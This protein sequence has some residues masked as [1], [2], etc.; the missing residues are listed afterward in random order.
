MRTDARFDMRNT[1][2]NS[3]AASQSPETSM[4]EV[5]S[6]ANVNYEKISYFDS[7]ALLRYNMCMAYIFSGRY[8]AFFDGIAHSNSIRVNNTLYE[9]RLHVTTNT[10]TLYACNALF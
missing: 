5:D 8:Y 4:D 2:G 10:A 1:H 9:G 6:G 7:A 3:Y